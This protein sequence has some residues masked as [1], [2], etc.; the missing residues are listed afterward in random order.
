MARN[1]IFST[2]ATVITSPMHPNQNPIGDHER[3][4][5]F[6]TALPIRDRQ[7]RIANAAMINPT[8]SMS[9]AST[10]GLV[11]VTRPGLGEKK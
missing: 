9:A 8:Q 6:V 5:F 3:L 10:S 2:L 4:S 11:Y 7:T 1:W